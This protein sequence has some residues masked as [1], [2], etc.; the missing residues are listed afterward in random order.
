MNTDNHEIH[1]MH[2]VFYIESLLS[3][4]RTVMS[5]RNV[6]V[7]FLDQIQKGNFKDQNFLIDS[8]QNI[9]LQAASLSR[10]F[11]PVSNKKMYKRRGQIL[12]DTYG[13]TESNPLR[14]RDVRN[15]IEHFDEKLDEYLSK[16]ITGTVYPSYVGPRINEEAKHIFRAYFLDEA[17]F[18]IFDLEYKVIPITN[19]IER[20][21]DLLERDLEKRRFSK[22]ND[23]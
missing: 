1:P 12:R 3:I 5:E 15:F 18:K 13:I 22:T 8:I 7:T 2:E 6:T 9:I 16:F 4:T 14:N 17:V 20:I 11:W 10:F 19:E 23:N 21:N